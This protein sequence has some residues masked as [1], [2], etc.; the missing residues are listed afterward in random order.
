[1]SRFTSGQSLLSAYS[2]GTTDTSADGDGTS[3]GLPSGGIPFALLDKGTPND[4]PPV[5]ETFAF[6]YR[7][8]KLA[9]ADIIYQVEWSE[10]LA[11]NDWH[12]TGVTEEILSDDDSIQQIQATVPAG[13]S[14]S[15][16]VHLKMTRP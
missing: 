8:N 11:D 12:T 13:T 2:T 15:R 4:G 16:F 1:V 6:H 5:G 9:L 14:G 10:T 3:V 7:R